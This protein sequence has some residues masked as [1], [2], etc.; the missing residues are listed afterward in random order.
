MAWS[1]G[2]FGNGVLS[3]GEFW[4][5][6]LS[7]LNTPPV[8]GPSQV[9][10]VAVPWPAIRRIRVTPAKPGRLIRIND[11]LLLAFLLFVFMA[12]LPKPSCRWS[13][14]SIAATS[15]FEYKIV[16]DGAAA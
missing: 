10:T 11:L 14:G 12:N 4:F 5:Q 8:A 16:F 7:S 9:V 2:P 3:P 6:L 15:F 1:F 13:D